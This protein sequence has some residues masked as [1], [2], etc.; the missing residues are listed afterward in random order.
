MSKALVNTANFL[1]H[2][3][4]YFVKARLIV[5]LSMCQ[6]SSSQP[7]TSNIEPILLLTRSSNQ[8]SWYPE[9]GQIKNCEPDKKEW[10]KE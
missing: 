3:Y 4:M 1:L 2:V 9:V 6:V 8:T 5:N 7:E 10:K